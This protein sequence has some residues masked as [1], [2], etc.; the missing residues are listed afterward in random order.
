MLRAYRSTRLCTIIC[1]ATPIFGR[2]FFRSTRTLPTSPARRRAR[3]A[4]GCTRPSTRASP[5]AA[6]ISPRS[7]AAGLVSAAS[8]T[9]A[10]SGRR[11]RR[12]GFSAGRFILLPSSSWSR[13]CGRAP[14]RGG[15]G[16]FRNSSAPTAKP[17]L[18]GRSF[19][20]STFRR[21]SSGRSQRGRLPPGAAMISLPR[22]LLDVFLGQDQSNERWG[23][24]LRFLSS[25]T[26]TGGLAI[27]VSR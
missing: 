18:V 6:M 23:R 11:R 10:A 12:C 16:N 7:T 1:L 26:I 13:P 25:I 17:S 14:R 15:S 8:G 5:G 4:A 22:S 9:V 27:A 24:L 20:K 3:A 19:G 2:F 21:R